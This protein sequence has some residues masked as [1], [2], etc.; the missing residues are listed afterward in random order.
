MEDRAVGATVAPASVR[1]A[2]PLPPHRTQRMTAIAVEH[3]EQLLPIRRRRLV[4]PEGVLWAPGRRRVPAGED[5]LLVA[6]GGRHRLLCRRPA[7]REQ[8][9][10]RY[11]AR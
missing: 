2:G 3:T 1:E 9:R 4:T 10:C 7:Q 8:R 11:R 6:H 5:V